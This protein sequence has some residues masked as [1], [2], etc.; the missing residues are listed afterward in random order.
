MYRTCVFG[1]AI[2]LGLGA[3]PAAF[4]A[5]PDDDE[6][7]PGAVATPS[8]SKGGFE[9]QFLVPPFAGSMVAMLG[10]YNVSY[11]T[12][13]FYTGGAGYGGPIGLAGNVVGGFGYGGF[14]AGVQRRVWTDWVADASMLV[15]AGGGG[16]PAGGG[17]SVAL[18]PSVGA[19][20]LIGGGLRLTLGLGYL[21]LPTM[22]S[23]SGVL[24]GLRFESKALNLA[25]PVDE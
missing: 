13:D 6:R 5:A 19:S 25:M 17:V 21:L 3:M 15:G 4:A 14:V 2:F 24:L 12:P 7:G 11:R 9:V 20:R 23:N 10:G 18:A 22:G 16:G 8:L 1:I